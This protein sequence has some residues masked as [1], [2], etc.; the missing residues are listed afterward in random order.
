MNG[1]SGELVD[2]L[3]QNV[4]AAHAAGAQVLVFQGAGKNFSAGFDL[5]NLE[6]QSEGDL[7]LRFV[8]VEQLLHKVASSP[9]L[10]VGM[11]HGRN[12]GA[13]VDLFGVCKWRCS[14]QDA[15]FRMPGLKFGL[16][17]GTRR[18]AAIVGREAG[19][20]ILEA[21]RSFSALEAQRLG[22]ATHLAD[23]DEWENLI[24]EAVT[25]A[26][27]LTD[28]AR[29]GLYSVLAD[30]FADTDL[31]LLVRSAAAPGLKARILSYQSINL[32]AADK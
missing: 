18:F 11:A 25:C 7:L 1:L 28:A 19:R 31:A 14:T 15:S 17:L 2:A 24:T 26:T 29:A 3:L 6:E 27:S 5:S 21:A 20:A 4:D 9:C 8:R 32:N 30:E 12:F 22:F 13:G 10:T 16:I 23:P